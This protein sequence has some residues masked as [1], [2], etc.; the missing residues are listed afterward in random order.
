MAPVYDIWRARPPGPAQK[1]ET[2]GEDIILSLPR[3]KPVGF[4]RWCC[5][6]QP[7]R[8]GPL[9][10][11]LRSV[12]QWCSWDHVTRPRRYGGSRG[13]SARRQLRPPV[14][15]E[16]DELPYGTFPSSPPRTGR[17]PFNASGSPVWAFL[18]VRDTHLSWPSTFLALPLL[19]FPLCATFSHS[20]YYDGCVTMSLAAFRRSRGLSHLYVLARCRCPTHPLIRTHCPTVFLRG[21]LHQKVKCRNR[22]VLSVLFRV[23]A[24]CPVFSING[25]QAGGHW[26]AL[27]T[28]RV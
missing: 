10:P 4:S 28:A 3:L 27:C 24:P 5:H 9:R 1:Q 22:L 7:P 14:E 23:P 8:N 16:A 19:S 12:A 25:P 2:L 13:T 6:R 17:A 18:R 20:E 15:W 11:D 21:F 26:S